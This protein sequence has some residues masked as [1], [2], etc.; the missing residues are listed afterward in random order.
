MFQT[1]HQNFPTAQSDNFRCLVLS[2]QQPQYSIIINIKQDKT[3]KKRE[4]NLSIGKQ[5]PV[6]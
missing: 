3:E 5:K 4:K 2:N 6:K 1:N